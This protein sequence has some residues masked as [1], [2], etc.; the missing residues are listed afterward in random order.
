VSRINDNDDCFLDNS[1]FMSIFLT[2]QALMYHNF[3][4]LAPFCTI[5]RANHNLVS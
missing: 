3:I 4:N 5:L 1:G 2:F